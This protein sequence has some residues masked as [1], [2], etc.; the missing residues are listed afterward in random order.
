MLGSM[1][2]SPEEV[3]GDFVEAGVSEAWFYRCAHAMIYSVLVESWSAKRSCDLITL[4]QILRKRGQLEE[5]GGPAYVVELASCVSTADG[6]CHFRN[7]VGEKYALRQ[8]LL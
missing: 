3:I 2:I 6:A 8:S 4:V 1:L 5:V 7:I